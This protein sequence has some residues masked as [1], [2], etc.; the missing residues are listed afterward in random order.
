MQSKYAPF[1]IKTHCFAH[2][3]NLTIID[4]IKSNQGLIKLRD[5]F[6]SLYN[7]VSASSKRTVTLRAIQYILEEPQLYIKEPHSIRWL[8][9]NAAVYAV[10]MCYRSVLA[11]LSKLAS[12][13]DDAAKGL[14][15]YFSN[16]KVA[17]FIAMM[18]DIHS[19]LAVLSQNL[20]KQDLLFSDTPVG[21]GL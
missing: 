1:I 13:K 5:N 10:Y 7:F 6:G 18:L 21:W 11:T 8:G 20:Q 9:L 2:R 14:H 3:L 12:E 16:Y 19:D 15:K 17:L 4:S